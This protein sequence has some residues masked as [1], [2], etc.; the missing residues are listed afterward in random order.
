[1]YSEWRYGTTRETTGNR[2]LLFH[3]RLSSPTDAQSAWVRRLL[4]GQIWRQGESAAGSADKLNGHAAGRP[5]AWHDQELQDPLGCEACFAM[6][7]DDHSIGQP[8]PIPLGDLNPCCR[9][10]PTPFY[11]SEPYAPPWLTRTQ[12]GPN[13]VVLSVLIRKHRLDRRAES[14]GS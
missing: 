7:L 8:R 3:W 1:M 14:H 5:S 4:G 2:S 9:V 6:D 10:G 11:E 13:H 12:L